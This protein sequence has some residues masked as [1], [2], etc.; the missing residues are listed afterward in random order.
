M[1]SFHLILLASGLASAVT[2]MFSASLR[3]LPYSGELSLPM[4]GASGQSRSCWGVATR[5]RS[6]H[7]RQRLRRNYTRHSLGW[8]TRSLSREVADLEGRGASSF[9]PKKGGPESLSEQ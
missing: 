6:G 4:Q 9:P 7:T 8:R 1:N 5:G 3:I 2:A